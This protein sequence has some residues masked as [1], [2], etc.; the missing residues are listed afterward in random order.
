LIKYAVAITGLPKL[1]KIVTDVDELNVAGLAGSKSSEDSKTV[2]DAGK[3]TASS[4]LS[5][6]L[7][8]PASNSNFKG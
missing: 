2:E 8:S 6:F 5:V 3:L 4:R 7:A 1:S